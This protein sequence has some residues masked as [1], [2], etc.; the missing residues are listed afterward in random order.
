MDKSIQSQLE[1]ALRNQEEQVHLRDKEISRLRA[2]LAALVEASKHMLYIFD[3]QLEP[4]T[5]GRRACDEMKA[6][7]AAA[8]SEAAND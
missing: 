1:Q 5:I 2:Q 3:R 6:A 8:E 7:I 4:G